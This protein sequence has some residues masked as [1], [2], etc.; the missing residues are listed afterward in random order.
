MRRHRRAEEL[1]R[2]DESKTLELKSIL[3]WNLKEGRKD[4][5][6]VTH[7]VLMTVA[8]FLNTEGGD[9]FVRS[10][11]GTVRLGETDVEE[12]VRTR[13]PQKSAVLAAS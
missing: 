9:L 6:Q 5:N 2:L 4:E 10:E 11:P 13:F 1:L 12:Y 3:R 7:T 8:A